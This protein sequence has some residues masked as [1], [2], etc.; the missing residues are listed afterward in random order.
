[1]R[2]RLLIIFGPVL[3]LG[4]FT[5]LLALVAGLFGFYR[6][7]MYA[8][9][10]AVGALV[11]A[12]A[13]FLFYQQA[14]ERRAS[15][16]ALQSVQARVGDI[17]D[18]AM[19]AIIS[20]DE[21]QRIVLYNPAAEKVF[22]WPRDAVL[23]QPLDRLLPERFRHAHQAHIAQFG[24]TGATSRRMG[25][26]GILYGLRASGEEFPI[27]AS[28]SQHVEND[29][30]LFTVILR[31]VTGR[32]R[33]QEALR[34]SQEELRE[35][36]AAA[37]TVREQEQRRVAREIHDELGQ[38]LTALKMDVA[39][40]LGNLSA[41]SPPL[42]DKL[43][44]MQTQLDATVAATRRISADL[45]PLMLD[46]L[47]LIPAAEW[48]AQ[49]FSE[50]T[51]IPCRMHIR[52][53][54]IELAEPHASALYRI[55]QES[56]T[57]VARHAR[58]SCVDVTLERVDGALQLTVRDD[59]RGFRPAEARAQKTYGLLGLRERTVLLGGDASVTSEPGRGTTVEVRL[60]LGKE[61]P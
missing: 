32:V 61:A 38:A 8:V 54:D 9:A 50:R 52:P 13:I 37:H 39:W 27:D 28:I 51:G 55:L 20:A 5:V 45:R 26:P 41:G 22:G 53:P 19:D 60:P 57:N 15:E 4:V 47:G 59:G 10:V 12:L 18:S 34:R 49:N 7:E 11:M 6:Y 21:S 16:A 24:R 14:G 42:A 31:D 44:A 58:A 33:A 35:L 29:K 3:A 1:M 23:G 36:S 48:L 2:G 30:R 40:M 43:G 46:D 56:L 25:D 17:V